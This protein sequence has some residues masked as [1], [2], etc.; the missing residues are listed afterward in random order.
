LYF[1]GTIDDIRIHN[2]ALSDQEALD[3]YHNFWH[4][5]R[6]SMYHAAAG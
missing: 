1:N 4:Q 6:A 3:A 2:R 5:N